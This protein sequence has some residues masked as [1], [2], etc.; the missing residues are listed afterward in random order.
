MKS[1]SVV[2]KTIVIATV[3]LAMFVT[4][5]CSKKSSESSVSTVASDAP[6]SVSGTPVDYTM[7]TFIPSP[8]AQAPSAGVEP[9]VQVVENQE[10]WNEVWEGYGEAPSFSDYSDNGTLVIVFGGAQSRQGSQLAVNGLVDSDGAYVVTATVKVPPANCEQIDPPVVPYGIFVTQAP[11]AGN[12]SLNL[13]TENLTE[14][15]LMQ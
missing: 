10:Q 4:S 9:S 14:C 3:A 6:T 13:Q 7:L 15:N 12:I 5:A 11:V 1:R 8:V 2:A